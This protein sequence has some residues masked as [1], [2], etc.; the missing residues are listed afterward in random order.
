ML[1]QQIVKS[2]LNSRLHYIQSCSVISPY[3][4]N[5][6]LTTY[7]Y[8]TNTTKINTGTIQQSNLN[9]PTPSTDKLQSTVQRDVVSDNS[10]LN[11]GSPNILIGLSTVIGGV[12]SDRD[13]QS[14]ARAMKVAN[15]DNILTE[16]HLSH[17]LWSEQYVNSVEQTH[18]ATVR[19]VDKLAAFTIKCIRFNFDWMS[20]W[21]FGKIT[22]QKALRRI[23]FLESVAGVPGSVAGIIRHLASLR[24]LK[25]DNG[26][27]HTLFEE[28]ENERMHLMTY[29]TLKKPTA[30]LKAAIWMSQGVFFNFFFA[31]YIIS[32]TFCHSMV[33]YLEEEA[34]ST[35]THILHAIDTPDGGLNHW[36]TQPA[37]SIAIAYWKMNSDA[38][39]RDVVSVTRADESHH[40]DVNHAFADM[41]PDDSNPFTPTHE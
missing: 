31:A 17:E 5:S 10:D 20:G 12:N 9:T 18:K 38:T 34:V 32:P 27:I 39:M 6:I 23:V 16:T 19:F 15:K 13:E 24:R 4:F 2:V 8:N 40:R 28:A 7:R 22:E 25:R 14:I 26:W 29:M 36:A 1:R 21:S 35:Y 37:P 3:T 30:P 41:K 11:G 33:G